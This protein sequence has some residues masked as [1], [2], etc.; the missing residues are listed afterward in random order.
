MDAVTELAMATN[1]TF[2]SILNEIQYSNLNFSIKMT[3]FAAYITLKKSVQKDIN[4]FYAT[5][6]PPLLFL[7][8]QAQDEIIRLQTENTKL[9]DDCETLKKKN[10]I[11]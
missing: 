4:G 10:D 8:Q 9:R 2:S 3:P 1:T 5:P 6:S 11:K 7:F